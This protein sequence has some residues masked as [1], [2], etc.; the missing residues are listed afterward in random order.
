MSITEGTMITP[1]IRLVREVSKNEESTLWL[2]ENTTLD[3][4]TLVRTLSPALAKDASAVERFMWEAQ[5]QANIE[6]PHVVSV[7]AVGTTP[8]NGVPYAL[9]EYVE[10]EDLATR[11]DRLGP[12]TPL[13]AAHVVGQ[14]AAALT[15]THA[16]GLAHHA[17]SAEKVLCIEDGGEIEC[18]LT[19]FDLSG[20]RSQAERA[21]RGLRR[22]DAAWMSPEQILAPMEA[23][24]RADL[25]GLAVIAYQCLTGRLP[26]R[27][28]DVATIF[29][30]IDRTEFQAPTL[31]KRRLPAGVD[32]FFD[33]AFRHRIEERFATAREL[34]DAFHQA[35]RTAPRARVVAPPF[36]EQLVTEEGE[37]VFLLGER[38]P[39]TDRPVSYESDVDERD[40]LYEELAS[41][42]RTQK[43]RARS[44]GVFLTAL[45]IAVFAGIAYSGSPGARRTANAAVQQSR[46]WGTMV[47]GTR[48]VLRGK[49]VLMIPASNDAAGAST[50]TTPVS[51]SATD[52]TSGARQTP[53]PPLMTPVA[54]AVRSDTPRRPSE[55][56]VLK[57]M[58]DRPVPSSTEKH[59]QPTDNPYFDLPGDQPAP[60]KKPR[61]HTTDGSLIPDS[62]LSQ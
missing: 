16:A 42:R 9:L 41:E 62:R 50:S 20:F 8:V 39:T 23:D 40:A 7:Y 47:F 26:F 33:R 31:L 51:P 32:A 53:R 60:D 43:K 15:A 34:A 11:I 38:A 24:A 22:N 45:V 59:E 21:Q 10:G 28:Q 4:H 37:P 61:E 19:G 12:L 49:S 13:D 57:I 55:P 14:I 56:R 54:P 46:D 2:A 17:V 58:D 30:T 36:A 35:V 25:W 29:S 44:V 18:K 48:T 27:G 3:A 1:S 5:R 6:S 52:A